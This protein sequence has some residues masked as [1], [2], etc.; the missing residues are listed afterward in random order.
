[1]AVPVRPLSEINEEAIR[2]LSKEMGA[3]DTARF[4]SQFTTAFG[5][6]TSTMCFSLV[7]TSETSRSELPPRKSV[8][9]VP[10]LFCQGST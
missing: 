8:N 3:A 5:A 6:S 7:L 4:I 1:M 2:L 10:D 9:H